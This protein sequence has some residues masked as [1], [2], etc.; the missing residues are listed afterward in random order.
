[1]TLCNGGDTRTFEL[2]YT[3]NLESL[4]RIAQVTGTN[5]SDWSTGF[6]DEN[7]TWYLSLTGIGTG[8]PD[9]LEV[10][11]DAEGATAEIDRS[12][13]NPVV[14]LRNGEETCT[15]EIRYRFN[16]DVFRLEDVNRDF[17]NSHFALN[18]PGPGA[19][20][21]AGAAATLAEVGDVEF[22]CA[23]DDA[24][25][26]LDLDSHPDDCDG[27]CTV[28]Y[29]DQYTYQYQVCYQPL[30]SGAALTLDAPMDV[31]IAQDSWQ[32]V[33]FTPEQ[34]GTYNL[35]A[36]QCD[37]DT[38]VD[39]YNAD[40]KWVTCNDDSGEGSNFSLSY[41]LET[42]HTYF[43]IVRHLDWDAVEM[44]VILTMGDPEDAEEEYDEESADDAAAAAPELT[45]EPT[46]E[47]ETVSVQTVEEESLEEVEAVPEGSAD[48]ALTDTSAAED[49]TSQD[50][51]VS[52]EE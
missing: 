17:A 9:D 13:E 10:T 44:K 4:F 24:E 34:S 15:Y 49:V 51:E 42:G 3:R 36:Y 21:L 30:S 2:R 40:G 38:Y 23:F 31:E 1:M 37:E 7:D 32:I 20:L 43:C 47:V 26:V 8:I 19:I 22:N 50:L 52:P 6:D 46:Q 41:A 35:R 25:A 12:G 18:D 16:L 29:R 33:R 45:Q 11:P 5:I 39:L 27:V 28:T 48:T 14:I